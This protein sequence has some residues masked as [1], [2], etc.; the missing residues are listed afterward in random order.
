MP[1]T[2]VFCVV[3]RDRRP[4]GQ[5]FPGGG[6]WPVEEEAHTLYVLGGFLQ[7]LPPVYVRQALE[8]CLC[9]AHFGPPGPF[10]AIFSTFPP[11]ACFCF[12]SAHQVLAR[13][14]AG[15]LLPTASAPAS[16]VL[17]CWP[18]LNK[19]LR[20][21]VARTGPL[22]KVAAGSGGWP[23]EE[24]ARTLYVLGGFL[25]PLPPVYARQALLQV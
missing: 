12:C 9:S 5:G 11:E 18:C 7:P 1:V 19:R 20:L 10:P 4:S 8:T 15:R 24:E 17:V 2:R 16:C 3:L 25:Q 6:G 22:G 14:L 23:V 21:G 13:S